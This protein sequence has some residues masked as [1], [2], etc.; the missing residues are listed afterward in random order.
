MV[1]WHVFELFDVFLSRTCRKVWLFCLRHASPTS[2][3]LSHFQA[4]PSSLSLSMTSTHL[5]SNSQHSPTQ[6]QYIWFPVVIIHFSP[7]YNLFPVLPVLPQSSKPTFHRSLHLWFLWVNYSLSIQILTQYPLHLLIP[8]L[9]PGF[10]A[11]YCHWFLTGPSLLP[12]RVP[13]SAQLSVLVLFL[14]NHSHNQPDLAWHSY[15]V[16]AKNVTTPGEFKHNLQRLSIR[17]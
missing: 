6:L 17:R 7:Q 13:A 15:W 4:T 14:I 9:C 8:S 3:L 5:D 1:S 12:V 10:N 11:T 2:A 16:L